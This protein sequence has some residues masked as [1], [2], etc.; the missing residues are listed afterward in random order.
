MN[1]VKELPGILTELETKYGH[2]P[3]EKAIQIAKSLCAVCDQ[4]ETVGAKDRENNR[5][6]LPPAVF[7][8]MTSDMTYKGTAEDKAYACEVAALLQQCYMD[9]YDHKSHPTERRKY[10]GK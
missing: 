5:R 8:G 3:T 4:I 9:G 10:S 6:A 7:Q 2:Q 1:M